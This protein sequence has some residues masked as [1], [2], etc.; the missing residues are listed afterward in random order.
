MSRS[1]QVLMLLSLV[2]CSQ[3]TM[4]T[5][6][7]PK[8]KTNVVPVQGGVNATAPNGQEIAVFAGGC[9]W[10]TE[11]VFERVRGVSTVV[12]GYAGDSKDLAVYELVGS[13]TTK[14][15]ESIQITY[16]P[17]Q[18]TYGDLLHIFFGV[19]DPTT[20]NY[21][22][23]DH[24]TQ[25]R[26]TIFYLNDEQKR[27]AEAYIKQLTDEKIFSAPIVTTIEPIGEGFFPA[28]DY[29]QDFVAHHPD[30]P[31]VQAW[32]VPK[33]EKLTTKYKEYLKP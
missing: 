16:D 17:K 32:S 13:G 20:K 22:G 14:H 10:C 23:P 18:I 7:T 21:Q 3:A 26:S 19:I 15:A 11:A 8:P 12:S 5:E 1:L 27:V 9:F 6:E 31:Y 29:H 4:H 24:G 33:I 2:G 30:H 28:E 25:Y